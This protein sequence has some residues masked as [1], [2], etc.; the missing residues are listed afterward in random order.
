VLWEYLSLNRTGI[1]KKGNKEW[2]TE[3]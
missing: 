1:T 2:G 3:K